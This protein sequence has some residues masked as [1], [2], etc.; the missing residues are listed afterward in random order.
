[1]QGDAATRGISASLFGLIATCFLLPFI[2]VSCAEDGS[3]STQQGTR[4]VRTVAIARGWQLA[5]GAAPDRP[6][7]AQPTSGAGFRDAG[8]QLLASA[9]MVS[10]AA[11][12]IICVR[13]R[14]PW[15]AAARIG[16][17]GTVLILVGQAYDDHALISRFI[18]QN[19]G[20]KPS[21]ATVREALTT[22]P[23]IGFWVALTTPQQVFDNTGGNA[24]FVPIR[25]FM[26]G[27]EAPGQ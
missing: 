24:G 5:A 20:G 15:A 14:R 2:G 22:R 27:Q 6:G 9:T 26:S 17:T 19:G 25:G 8:V 12:M 4:T 16:A 11:G 23:E 10:A 3:G 18:G 13:R 1:M 21:E 7:N